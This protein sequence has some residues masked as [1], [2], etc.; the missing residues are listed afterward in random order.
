MH[1][2]G[3]TTFIK[4]TLIIVDLI[5][6]LSINDTQQYLVKT[7]NVIRLSFF[8]LNVGLLG[9]VILSVVM[10]KV[11]A[12]QNLKCAQVAFI[13]GPGYSWR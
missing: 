10:L 11:M 4:M 8:L 1:A 5:V 2:V 6:T 7:I 12:P 3:A 13:G 9:V